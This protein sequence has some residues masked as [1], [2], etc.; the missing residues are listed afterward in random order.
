L[1]YNYE[2]NYGVYASMLSVMWSRIQ[3]LHCN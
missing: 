3:T 2:N 1:Y